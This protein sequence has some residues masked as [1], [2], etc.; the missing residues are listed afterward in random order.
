VGKSKSEDL[1]AVW[2]QSGAVASSQPVLANSERAQKIFSVCGSAQKGENFSPEG[3]CLREEYEYLL[4]VSC[5]VDE[6]AAGFTR[7]GGRRDVSMDAEHWNL[8]GAGGL[9]GDCPFL[10]WGLSEL[11]KGLGGGTALLTTKLESEA[12]GGGSL[13]W[14]VSR[15]AVCDIR[16]RLVVR[17]AGQPAGE[18]WVS[19]EASF[20]IALLEEEGQFEVTSQGIFGATDTWQVLQTDPG[21]ASSEETQAKRGPG[22]GGGK[23]RRGF[24]GGQK[25]GVLRPQGKAVGLRADW[26][27]VTG[28]G[29][30][31][32]GEAG[33]ARLALKQLT[34]VAGGDGGDEGGSRPGLALLPRLTALLRCFDGS[35]RLHNYTDG[36]S[37]TDR[38]THAQG[39]RCRNHGLLTLAHQNSAEDFIV[40]SLAAPRFLGGQVCRIVGA[41]AALLSAPPAAST[42]EVEYIKATLQ[43]KLL[44]RKSVV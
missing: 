19:R 25:K 26:G 38:S 18:W 24:K 44:D 4:P 30:L 28:V 8:Q 21:A 17:Q 37:A 35:P 20:P 3:E 29:W 13:E 14:C 42:G 40:I 27:G 9:R 43:R 22:E 39:V 10:G 7:A 15:G 36:A 33:G 32:D 34:V 23:G 12:V 31:V 16:V 5:C 41:I 1:A 2:D 6:S 11:G